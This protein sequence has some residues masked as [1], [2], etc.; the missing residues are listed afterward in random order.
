MVTISAESERIDT[1]LQIAGDVGSEPLRASLQCI[2][3]GVFV[4]HQLHSW[5]TSR[6]AVGCPLRGPTRYSGGGNMHGIQGRF[7][8]GR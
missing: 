8:V 1:V 7:V 2:G 5:G 4:G 6:Q 3:P